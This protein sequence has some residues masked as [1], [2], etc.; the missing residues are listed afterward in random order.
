[1]TEHVTYSTLSEA[2]IELQV[3][4]AKTKAIRYEYWEDDKFLFK[5]ISEELL[6]VTGI[7]RNVGV[8][9]IITPKETTQL[10]LEYAFRK[11]WIVFD[12]PTNYFKQRL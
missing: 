9:T 7:N 10:I 5:G 6:G 3:A 2:L 12:I 1:M 8:P 4:P 11:K